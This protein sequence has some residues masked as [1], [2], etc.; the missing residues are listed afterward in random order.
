MKANFA[1]VAI[2]FALFFSAAS[3]NNIFKL[4]DGKT[5]MYSVS[6]EAM[7]WINSVRVSHDL[8]NS[9]IVSFLKMITG[10]GVISA[11]TFQ[12][13]ADGKVYTFHNHLAQF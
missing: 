9:Y 12:N 5:V 7:T 11:T 4:K 13:C 1:F 10:C 8:T 6:E 3:C 2:A